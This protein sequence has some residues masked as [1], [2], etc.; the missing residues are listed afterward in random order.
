[1]AGVFRMAG[2]ATDG[3]AS[4]VAHEIGAARGVLVFCVVIVVLVFQLGGIGSFL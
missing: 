1:M 2:D 3:V 4:V